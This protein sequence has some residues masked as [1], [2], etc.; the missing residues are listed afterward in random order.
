M[1]S[2]LSEGKSTIRALQLAQDALLRKQHPKG[3][4]VG[5]LQGDSILESE[6]ILLKFI[7]EQE[8]DPDL[9]LIANYLRSLQQADGGWTLFPGGPSDLAGTVKA[10]FA[11]KLLGDDVDAPHM[12]VARDVV[13]KLGGAE[14]CNSFTKFY[15]AALGQISYDACPSIPPEII[16]IPKWIYFNLYAVSAW[17]RTMI[18]PLAIVSA[19]RP[20]RKLSPE[21]GI[22]EL[23]NDM[24]AANSAA[25]KLKGLPRSWR[26][27]FLLIDLS[28]KRYEKTAV[29]PLRPRAIREAEKW[30]LEHLEGS[31]GLGAIF[32]PMVYI[33]I[34]LRILGYS[35]NHPVVQ[36]A[37]RDLKDLF[38]RD[39]DTIRIQPCWSPVWDTGIA[40]HALA[41]AQISPDDP[42]A[43]KASQWLLAK[44][45]RIGSDWTK[46]C[47]DVE[48][49]GWFF[50]FENPHYPDVDDTAMVAM[51]LKRAGGPT[52]AAAVK[53]G[54]NWL[55][56]MQ[57]D[58]GGWAAFDRT[59]SRPILEHVPFADHNAI[60]DPS[61]PDIAGRTLECLGH[62]GLKYDH[63]AVRKAVSFLK[64]TQE[65]EGCWFGRWGVNYIYGTWQV[66]TGLRSVGEPMDQ[67]FIR[68][69]ADWLRSCQ[70]PDGSWGESCQTYDN[71]ELK[72]R[73]PST[74]SQTAWGAMGLMA[75]A[76]A[77]D[78]AVVRAI[79]WLVE[80][81]TP[82]GDW[83]EPWFTGTGFPRVFY[84]KYHL[85]RLYFPLTALA[86][87]QRLQATN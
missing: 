60:Q 4:W 86:R 1:P 81:Q 18:L 61:C 31:E 11:L 71:P 33:L 42:V 12:R 54:V 46:N 29:T 13:R 36:K 38:I 51:A 34:V 76:G 64:E 25:G 21:Q 45:C 32:P 59:R 43:Q 15:L 6:Y 2:T 35:D 53:R 66:L 74:P 62:N 49:S 17:S 41:E 80:N 85:Y 24:A 14:L 58:D 7:L 87:Y 16:L 37:H 40:L 9:P 22:L 3:Y 84:L 68:R 23:F 27:M 48:P 79:N 10:Y 39:G 65:K 28:L 75:V 57:N 55:L 19:F 20:V 26:E 63:P 70:K 52:A 72:G 50:E 47:P 5:E 77:Q 8:S 82:E 67:R 78:P 56:A 83:D 73:G 44:E 69:A 30:L